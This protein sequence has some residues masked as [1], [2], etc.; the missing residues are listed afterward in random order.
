MTAALLGTRRRPVP[1]LGDAAS[2]A[3]DRR[4]APAAPGAGASWPHD[5]PHQAGD[6]PTTATAN[7]P[8]AQHPW[9]GGGPASAGG[10]IPG[11]AGPLG[12]DPAGR[13]LDQAALLTVRRRAGRMPEA[14]EPIAPAP[15]ETTRPVP[16]AATRRLRRMLSGE[17]AWLLPEWL[18][19]AARNGRHVP[20][21]LL[22]ELLDRA[23][24]DRAL[25]PHLA[26][27][28]GRRGVWLAMRN[29]DWAY[30]VV[31]GGDEAAG[32]PAMWETGVRAQ[33]AGHLAR[34]RA[35]DPAAARATL[36]SAWAREPAAD[37]AAFLAT[38]E[39]NLSLD[40]EEFL[41]AALDDRGVDVR[42][43]AAGL[44]AR[45]PGSAYGGRMAG[46]AHAC[47]RPAGDGR[48]RWIVA[49]PPRD[50]DETMLRDGIPFHAA[51]GVGNRAGWLREILGRTPLSTWT[52]LF[53]ADPEQIVRLPVVTARDAERAANT[54][55]PAG[56]AGSE[57]AA[58][59]ADPHATEDVH[60]GWADAAVR[61][62][63][64]AWARALLGPR[65]A[66]GDTRTLAGLLDAL[67][68]AERDRAAAA[69]IR[70]L[71]GRAGLL[72]VLERIPGPWRGELADAVIEVLASV[73]V[74]DEAGT[75]LVREA[76]TGAAAR[77]GHVAPGVPF[78][79]A[80]APPAR[81][82]PSAGRVAAGL[83]GPAAAGAVP[84]HAGAVLGHAG[85]VPG[86]AARG[87]PPGGAGAFLGRAAAADAA[88][89]RTNVLAALARPA[90]ERLVPAAAPR[91]ADLA[92][93]YPGISPL[94]EL[95]ET[96]RFRHEM[97][98][99]LR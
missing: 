93:R 99:E 24:A 18:D 41:E 71:R 63:D 84:G 57:G 86:Q 12:G 10:G 34:L 22:P 33:R 1:S 51:A 7:S 31:A 47:L 82:A 35:T 42:R 96:L 48:H 46:R 49:D 98:E 58:P 90:G 26:R 16:G 97:N 21:S 37:R 72:D 55:E 23:R 75:A 54:R 13:L 9:H 3:G 85:V 5:D 81:S 70:P 77:P 64:A 8:A 53:G 68:E 95:A 2:P 79:A 17:R 78:A 61:Q 29:V 67:P 59:V 39:R 14:A 44:L 6:P 91:L 4:A 73:A 52:E 80:A 27:A 92:R 20:P 28:A 36:S 38:F 87:A 11:T 30:L 62:R 88:A 56:A 65:A 40:D 83:P 19:A 43:V 25:R 66:A 94:A 15:A 89:D 50:H 69:A 45:L 76:S 60:Q 32:D 74:G